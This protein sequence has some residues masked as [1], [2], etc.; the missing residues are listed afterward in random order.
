MNN[1]MAKLFNLSAIDTEY[2]NDDQDKIELVSYETITTKCKK[3]LSLV[4]AGFRQSEYY[5][6]EKDFDRAIEILQNTYVATF[7]LTES[8]SYEWGEFFR[9]TILES[10]ENM[11]NELTHLSKGLLKKKRFISSRNLAA[12]VISQLKKMSQNNKLHVNKDKKH[13]IENYQKRY[14]S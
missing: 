9:S 14:V 5:R 2:F 3:H 13:Y 4:N 12:D 1:K 11:H 6:R 10:L 8:S 7:E